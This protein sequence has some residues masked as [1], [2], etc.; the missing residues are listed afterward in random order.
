M[1]TDVDGVKM[2]KSLGNIISPYE[3]VD[4]YGSDTLRYYFTKTPAGEDIN[5]SWDQ[6]KQHYRNLSIY[7]NMTNYLLELIDQVGL[8]G[9]SGKDISLAKNSALLS[10][11]FAPQ[12]AQ[13]AVESGI[14]DEEKY[15]L[16][17]VATAVLAIDKAYETYDLA[18][19]GPLF[20]D[21]LLAVSR[22]YI[23]LIR[24][25][26]SQ[27][28]QIEQRA[29]VATLYD[30]I[31]RLLVV[32]HPVIPFVT[33]K[34][35]Q[36]LKEKVDN[37]DTECESIFLVP[38]AHVVDTKTL[39]ARENTKL[40][41]SFVIADSIM[42][43][44]LAAREKLNVGVRWPLSSA[45]IVTVDKEIGASIVLLTD[46]IKQQTNIRALNIVNRF[47]GV[48]YT[49]KPNYAA[50]KELGKDTATVGQLLN[51]MTGTE[52]KAMFDTFAAGQT[53]GFS[54]GRQTFQIKKE[55]ITFI[56][57][58]P[59]GLAATTWSNGQI[60]L[61]ADMTPELE[62]EGFARE[63][64]RRIQ[65]ARKD[66]GFA[67]KDVCNLVVATSDALKKSI[68]AN[69]RQIRDRC[70]LADLSFDV[71]ETDASAFTRTEKIK[72]EELTIAVWKVK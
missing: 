11:Q 54:V 8:S 69:E 64:M 2:S 37:V 24:D 41:D 21:A 71:A 55:Y 66:A 14:G 29:V 30:C 67:K 40:V 51:G 6:A 35:Y 3:I 25:K 56:E 52:A 10:P 20:E 32:A 70:G 19:I 46:L 17:K 44:L 5:F 23:Q 7:Y 42:Q 39:V 31:Y 59:S 22:T 4:K 60:Y 48:T 62:A 18:S 72:N 45:T 57:T 63:A 33:E 26:A 53:Y 36:L 58:V 1:L 38:W 12:S 9:K 43:G 61:S 28:T 16:S 65:T 49:L 27:G 34:L 13:P 15:I 47:D 68:L 50:L